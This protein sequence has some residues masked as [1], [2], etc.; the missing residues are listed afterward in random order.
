MRTGQYG[1]WFYRAVASDS[2]KHVE[3]IVQAILEQIQPRS[4]VDVGCGVGHF[5]EAFGRSGVKDVFGIDLPGIHPD[6]L[7]IPRERFVGIDLASEYRADKKY[8]LVLSLEV[9]EHI[10]EAAANT[11]VQNLV[12]LGPVVVFSAAIPLQGGYRHINE[13]W[14]DYWVDKFERHGHVVVDG[15]RDRLWLDSRIPYYYRQN[16]LIFAKPS[17][18]DTYPRLL[19]ERSKTQRN[20]LA[21]VHPVLYE[22]RSDPSRTTLRFW[23]K[24]IPAIPAAT[25]KAIASRFRRVSI[26]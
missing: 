16:I 14:P 23:L 24:A 21:R 3:P 20:S 15:L 19:E 26:R 17:T 5:L 2:T 13:Q 6:L 11:F 10:P 12:A 9:G 8:D 7:R 1:D 18:I 25:W 22:I 4:V